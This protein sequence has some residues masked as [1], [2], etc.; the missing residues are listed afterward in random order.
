MTIEGWQVVADVIGHVIW[1]ALV[2]TIVLLFRTQ[3]ASF[4]TEVEEADWGGAKL[5]RGNR[6]S[7]ELKEEASD[8]GPDDTIEGASES[9]AEI[10]EP[11]FV[12][13]NDVPEP[14]RFLTYYGRTVIDRLRSS[15]YN[16]DT[17]SARLGAE[18][19][20]SS[21]AD[22]KQAVRIVAFVVRG[23]GGS[24]GVIPGLTKNLEVLALPD[25]L[26]RDIRDA[27]QI[28]VDVTE[29]RLRVDGDGASDYIDS[30]RSLVTRLI[31]WALSEE[32]SK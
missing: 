28:A 7:R 12:P 32:A 22:L 4:I 5:K 2:I 16:T 27:R 9:E 25:D 15:K 6:R 21:Y 20:G 13:E 30:I 3:I 8:H 11:Q 23:S 31:R 14:F 18:I 17:T 26:D 29:K 1:P 24:R 19:V 10:V